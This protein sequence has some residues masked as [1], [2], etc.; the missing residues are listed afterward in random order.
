MSWGDRI[1]NESKKTWLEKFVIRF[2]NED[3]SCQERCETR[4]LLF[5]LTLYPIGARGVH[6]MWVIWAWWAR[7]PLPIVLPWRMWMVFR[8][9]LRPRTTYIESPLALQIVIER[10]PSALCPH[11]QLR[12]VSSCKDL[13]NPFEVPPL[14]PFWTNG[15]PNFWAR[16]EVRFMTDLWESGELYKWVLSL[17]SSALSELIEAHQSWC[18]VFSVTRLPELVLSHWWR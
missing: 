13:P 8:P 9:Y 5:S 7:P 14:N 3:F 4:G 12:E 16:K 18:H 6:L 15:R 10:T 17:I 2:I 11:P 1:S